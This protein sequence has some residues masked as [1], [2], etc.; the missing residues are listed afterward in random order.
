MQ[1]HTLSALLRYCHTTAT[2]LHYCHTLHH[3]HTHTPLPHWCHVTTLITATHY[4]PTLFALHWSAHFAPCV[5][6]APYCAQSALA[7]HP[8]CI[9]IAP[10]LYMSTLGHHC[11][12]MWLHVT[13][14]DHKWT[15]KMQAWSN[16]TRVQKRAWAALWLYALGLHMDYMLLDYTASLLTQKPVKTITQTK[17]KNRQ[18]FAPRELM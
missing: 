6:C 12:H 2:L 11:D 15:P 13:T 16:G 14:I 17:T 8:M 9:R 10:V 1:L 7:L 3:C 5:L 4:C 18:G